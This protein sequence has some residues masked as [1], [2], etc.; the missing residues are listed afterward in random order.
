MIDLQTVFSNKPCR[1]VFLT[2]LKM[3]KLQ[4][5]M[6]PQHILTSSLGNCLEWFDF[7][8]FLFLAPLIGTKFFH[9]QNQ[10][11]A[12]LAALSVFATGFIARPLGGILFGH[13]GDRHGRRDTLRYSILIMAA[14]TFIIGCLPTYATIG[15]WASILF[16]M[17]RIIQGFSVG[18]E[19]SGILI[20]LAES[21]PSENRGLIT[22]FAATG[23]NVGFLLATLVILFMQWWLPEKIMQ[24][25]G[26]RLPFIIMGFFS[27]LLFYLRLNL[28]ETP[29]YLYLKQGQHIQQ[30]PLLAALRKAW[31]TLLKIFSISG[32]NSTFYYIFFG[33]MPTYLT[34][35]VGIDTHIA[36]LLQSA[37]LVILIFLVPIAGICG[38]RFG[39]KKM[40]LF[41]AMSI[42]LLT[43]PCF[44]LLHARTIDL[45]AL[46]L[47]IAALI[48]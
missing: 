12:T 5:I 47:G 38:D 7:G 37:A 10:N 25:W 1:R 35:N 39:R 8:L 30:R 27:I 36:F 28:L 43:L 20:Y 4:H 19:Y 41:T 44:Y 21:A 11:S 34:N 24:T 26:W 42:I 23:A 9:T 3:M 17:F 31:P 29:V 45:I 40:L 13:L 15:I 6:K 33:Y 22:S 16:V 18:G 14:V 48:S 2:N 32:M 46:A